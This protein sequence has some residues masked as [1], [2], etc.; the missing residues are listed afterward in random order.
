M[1]N[2]IFILCKTDEEKYDKC[3]SKF[4]V[5]DTIRI[6]KKV[7]SR[8]EGWDNFWIEEMD[9]YINTIGVITYIDDRRS[10]I[11]IADMLFTFP[12]QA[13]EKI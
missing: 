13:L 7:K 4:K 9:K 2:K 5:G 3:L 11:T 10:G 8:S 12:P 1:D 6:F